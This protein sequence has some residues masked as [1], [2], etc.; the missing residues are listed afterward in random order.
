MNKI[1]QYLQ[2]NHKNLLSV[3][4]TAGFPALNDT[5]NIIKH[6]Q[7]NRVDMI[8]VGI[9]F[10]DPIADGPIIQKSNAI[11]LENGMSL[12]LLFRQLKELNSPFPIPTLLMGYLNPVFQY[13]IEKFCNECRNASIDGVI[14]PDMP[15]EF[16]L[17]EYKQTFEKYN[18]HN[19]SI[20]SPSTPEE[21]LKKIVHEATGFIYLVS[22]SSTTGNSIN[23]DTH[24][25]Y[26][27]KIKALRPELPV[28]VGFGIDSPNKFQQVCKK[29][30]GG[31]I[32]SAF[33]KKISE[34]GNI[35][36]LIKQFIKTIKTKK[37]DHST[38]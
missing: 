18:L 36:T 23:V 34:K 19:I 12:K 10:S 1:D 35:E 38:E 21:R 25:E 31:I 5:T 14:I 27:D 8:E 29:A 9:P 22:S 17:K 33:I 13:G 26:V 20:I 28:L 32:G 16:F 2:K 7:K 24:L 6:L 3:F 37:N 4:F 11:A 15:L 30:N